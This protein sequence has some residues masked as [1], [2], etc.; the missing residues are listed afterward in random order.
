MKV[1]RQKQILDQ[2]HGLELRQSPIQVQQC[3]GTH[4]TTPQ[5]M[6]VWCQ[7]KRENEARRG[8]SLPA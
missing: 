7:K 4:H 3:T 1:W 6:K 2:I 8:F 5:L